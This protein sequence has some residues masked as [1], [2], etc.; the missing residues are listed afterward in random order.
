MLQ[1]LVASPLALMGAVDRTELAALLVK[2]DQENLDR[3]KSYVFEVEDILMQGN[4]PVREQSFEV[5]LLSGSLY[6]RKLTANGRALVGEDLEAETKRYQIHL[7]RA[8]KAVMDSSWVKERAAFAGFIDAMDCKWGKE[9]K[10]GGRR[11]VQLNV[12]PRGKGGE[13]G[14][15]SHGDAEIWVDLETG[16]WM[17]MNLMVRGLTHVEMHQLYMGRL[18]LPYSA[19]LMNRMD[20]VTGAVLKHSLMLHPEGIWVPQSSIVEG[21]NY[22][23]TLTFSK[24]H[25]FSADS[26]LKTDA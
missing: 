14:Y 12:K 4:R 7:Q 19:G 24:F 11:C 8:E 17:R 1:S 3:L 20:L 10:V 9:A 6:W 5:N 25:K 18:S 2:H 15:L 22:R 16:H 26:V 13:F 23:S 21:R